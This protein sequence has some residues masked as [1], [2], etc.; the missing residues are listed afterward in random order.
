MEELKG[1]E[2]GGFCPRATRAGRPPAQ[3]LPDGRRPSSFCLGARGPK[4]QGA[5]A[6]ATSRQ[7]SGPP[8]QVGT[9]LL[10]RVLEADLGRRVAGACRIIGFFLVVSSERAGQRRRRRA[11]GSGRQL[12]GLA[13]SL[14]RVL[15]QL[16]R[17]CAL[18]PLPR[19]VPP[20][21]SRATTPPPQKSNSHST[22]RTP[23]SSA[24]AAMGAAEMTAAAAKA[25]TRAATEGFCEVVRCVVWLWLGWRRRTR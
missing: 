22:A 20:P 4:K 15:L 13:L 3:Y 25:A 16:S 14:C 18:P 19:I 10:E 21:P 9:L 12:P 17:E 11:Q 1:D 24:K 5:R 2:A 6:H 7:E 8:R 23:A